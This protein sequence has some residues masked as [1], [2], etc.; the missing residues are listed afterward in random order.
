[1]GGKREIGKEPVFVFE[2]EGAMWI[3]DGLRKGIFAS[4]LFKLRIG[5]DT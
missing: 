2:A 4:I 1:M 3:V 5:R